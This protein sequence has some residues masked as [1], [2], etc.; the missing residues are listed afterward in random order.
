[1]SLRYFPWFP[2]V[3]VKLFS[4]KL[5][6]LL[7][8]LCLHSATAAP[9]FLSLALLVYRSSSFVLFGFCL[10][11]V[12]CCSFHAVPFSIS[13]QLFLQFESIIKSKHDTQVVA[14]FRRR[15]STKLV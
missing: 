11:L 15:S 1:M 6:S 2:C 8:L 9:H 12:F 4:G 3:S 7:Q 14:L 5:V 10:I 13:L